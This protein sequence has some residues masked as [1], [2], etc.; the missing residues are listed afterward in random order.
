MRKREG[1]RRAA[2]S[3]ALAGSLALAGA[4]IAFAD[5]PAMGANTGK[6]GSTKMNLKIDETQIVTL[7]PTEVPI[8]VK[9]DGA[10]VTP[11]NVRIE[12]QSVFAV[13][14]AK[15]KAEVA[16]DFAL[17]ASGQTFDDADTSDTLWMTATAGTDAIE[18]SAA[19]ADPTDGA[20]TADGQWNMQA[21]GAADNADKLPITLDGAVKKAT[22][23]KSD[24][25]ETAVTVTWVLA[26]GAP[27]AP[28][29]PAP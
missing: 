13:H 10:F 22:K 16:A 28:T 26:A 25:A 19:A 24:A 7:V 14:V 18:L 29:P 6:D 2:L 1:A 23:L 4:G 17:V 9:G 3:V 11:D 8:A 12:N 21:A 15:V 5:D 20:A 27:V